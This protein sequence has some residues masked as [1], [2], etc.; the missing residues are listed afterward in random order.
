M[1]CSASSAGRDVRE[2]AGGAPAGGGG[3]RGSGAAAAGRAD[4]GPARDARDA[5]RP[6]PPRPAAPLR[7]HL[8]RRHVLHRRL[9]Q[10]LRLLVRHLSSSP[11]LFRFTAS[12]SFVLQYLA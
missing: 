6:R 2:Q 11:S 1:L 4:E 12:S 7:G 8:A 3:A 5:R 10:R 9:R